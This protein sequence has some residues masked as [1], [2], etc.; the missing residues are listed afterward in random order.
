MTQDRASVPQSAPRQTQSYLRELLEARGLR[1]NGKLGQCFLIDLNLID[2]IL[3]EARLGPA[4]LVL[5]VGTGTG[6]LT[7][8]L[9][10]QA[11]AVLGVEI[12]RGLFALAQDLTRALPNVRLL[13][14]DILESKHRLNPRVLELLQEGLSRG[15][16]QQIKLVANLPY[17]VATPVIANLLLS[18]LPLER[19]VV[20]VQWELA[21]RLA[22]R[23]GTADYGALSVLVQSL[24]DVEL[25]RKLPPA[26]FW[27]RP[28][29]DSA[30]V[31]LLPQAE[32]RR[33]V[34]NVP[35][36]HQFLHDL[37]LHRRKNLRG[38]LLAFLGKEWSKAELDRHLERHDFDGQVRAETLG[39]EDHQRLAKL[40]MA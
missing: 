32:R 20:M 15:G 28:Q 4:D 19:M 26:A 23:P 18:E 37:Y 21:A 22:A 14:G 25:L 2:L 35:A 39:V 17:V 8:R 3:R 6:S 11:G 24:A 7:S 30:I 29:V 5:E 9:A 31:R 1:P 16:F 33:Q 40:F 38:A 36:F 10:Q 34:G 13:Q 27:P 12:D